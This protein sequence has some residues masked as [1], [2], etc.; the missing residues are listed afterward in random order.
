MEIPMTSRPDTP[1]RSVPLRIAPFAVIVFLG[2]LAVGLPLTTIPLY[3]RSTLGFN[4]LTVGIAVAAQSVATL[5]TRPFAGAVCDRAGPKRCV[6]LGTAVTLLAGLVSL[7][8]ASVTAPQVSLCVL[9]A[10]RLILGL[11]ESLVMTGGLAWAIGAVGAPHTGKVMVWIGIAMYAA[12]AAAAP[13]GLRLISEGFSRVA[14]VAAALAI[15]AAALAMMLAPVA[16]AGGQRLP[17]LR[18]ALRIAPFGCGLALATIGFGA[19]A[20]FAAIDFQSKGWSGPGLVLGSFGAAYI[21][22]R[23]LF[24]H[25]PDRFG[26]ARVAAWSLAVECAGQVLLWLAPSPIVA[27]GGAALTGLGFSLVFPSFGIEAVKQIPAASRGSALGAYVAFFDIGVGVSGPV[28]GLIAG[29]FGYPSVFAA[30]ALAAGAAIGLARRSWSFTRRAAAST[31][32]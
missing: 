18:V 4:D 8:A 32:T 30:G 9:L 14:L 26:G 25:W 29:T 13:L 12:I 1:P 10:G 5:L 17:F 27:I 24:G 28:T 16:P 23:L 21:L 11:G 7:I 2:Y 15:P 31:K 6:L 3:V 19:I 22:T 20:A